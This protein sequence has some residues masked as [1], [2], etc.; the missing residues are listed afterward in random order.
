MRN[1]IVKISLICAVA[2]S[3]VS[4]DKEEIVEAN[5]IP[6]AAHTF[7]NDY[8][9]DVPILSVVKEKDVLGGTTY[10]VLLNNGIEV[11]FDKNGQWDEVEAKADNAGIPTTFVPAKIVSYVRANYPDALINNIDKEKSTFEVEL[12]NGLDLV[13]NQ[14]GDFIRIDP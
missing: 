6:N 14:A 11:T 13:F 1:L 10:E 12:T 8:F 3:V 7:L 5:T 2:F 4:C 9:K